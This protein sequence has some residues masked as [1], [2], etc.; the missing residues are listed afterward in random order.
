[1]FSNEA[2]CFCLPKSQLWWHHSWLKNIF[3]GSLLPQKL[4]TNCVG[5]HLTSTILSE[6]VCFP[7]S[8]PIA[9]GQK[10]KTTS[11]MLIFPNACLQINSLRSP[12][13]L[14]KII[15]LLPPFLSAVGRGIPLSNKKL[16]WALSKSCFFSCWFQPKYALL[17]LSDLKLGSDSPSTVWLP[18]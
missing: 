8:Y 7:V 4:G 16:K 10:P 17:H 18:L 3:L 13:V 6:K 12:G 11:W 5:C 14:V 1:M 9:L 15:F 2:L